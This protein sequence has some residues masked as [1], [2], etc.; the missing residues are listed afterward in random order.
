[1]KN[2]GWKPDRNSKAPLYM[3]IKQFIIGKI[4]SGEWYVGY[5]ILPQREIAE[6]FGV[7]RS[8]IKAALEDLTADGIL[9]TRGKVGTYVQNN[10]WSV[11]TSNSSP[12]WKT[13][14]NAGSLN[15]NRKITQ[16]I[17]QYEFST[18]LIRLSTGELSQELIPKKAISKVF[19]EL[20]RKA[21]YD[22]KYEHQNGSFNLRK[23]I[24]NYYRELNMDVSPEQVLLVS[25]GIQA[26]QLISM[27]LLPQGAS[28]ICEKLSYLASL[29]IFKSLGVHLKGVDIRA[30]GMDMSELERIYYKSHSPICYLNPYF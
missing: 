17:Y 19:A 27:G 26:I 16:K 25:G 29:N 14:I 23:E 3:Q 15:V 9:E 8:T 13:Y 4:T 5:R 6:Y 18:N 21:D 11:L 24:C 30:D 10:T 7:N 20:G 12:D 28:I 1:M 22:L 2:L